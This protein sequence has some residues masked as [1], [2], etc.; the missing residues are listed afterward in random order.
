M[1]TIGLVPEPPREPPPPRVVEYRPM[2]LA[3]ITHPVDGELLDDLERVQRG[4]VKEWSR[5][6]MN[7]TPR[8]GV[9]PGD[10]MIAQDGSQDSF[11][12]AGRTSTAE[13][14]REV[15]REVTPR[16]GVVVGATT[17]AQEAS[18]EASNQYE[19]A[20][21]A[22]EQRN[23]FRKTTPR[24]GVTAGGSSS[25]VEGSKEVVKYSGGHATAEVQHNPFRKAAKRD[26]SGPRGSTAAKENFDLVV[27]AS[28]SSLPKSRIPSAVGGAGESSHKAG[29]V[30]GLHVPKTSKYPLPYTITLSYTT[31][32]H[33]HLSYLLV[34]ITQ[35]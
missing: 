30:G 5:P 3:G 2:T 8:S 19:R 9:D 14:Q 10:S 31:D 15:F 27:K 4:D 6:M 13:Q 24:S 26:V 25:V 28:G 12:F 29:A 11:S 22:E 1:F 33:L 34:V 35:P 17:S 18:L 7:I 21:S 16:S 20:L 23:P 32:D